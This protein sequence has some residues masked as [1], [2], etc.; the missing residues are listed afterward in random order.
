MVDNDY[1]T[2][3]CKSQKIIIGAI[4]KN[5]EML[6]FVADHLKTEKMYKH[7]VT[8]LFMLYDIF[9]INIRLHQCVIKQF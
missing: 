3:D 8:K 1:S 4:M 2:E 7:A 5:S 9:L 6:M